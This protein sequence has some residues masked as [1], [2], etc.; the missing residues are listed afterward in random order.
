MIAV[1]TSA[2]IAILKNEPAA[3][4]CAQAL[5]ADEHVVISAGTLA[6]ALIVAARRNL[7]LE[8]AALIED[9]QWRVEAVTQTSATRAADAY[10]R[11]GKGMHPAGLNY[12]DCFAYELASRMNCPLLY[13]GDDFAK[14][15][16]QSAL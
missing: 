9:I 8:L 13:V 3:D 11:W 7:S 15:D 4:R 2:I 1:D 6:E 10:N 12:G 14:T 16:I 5:L